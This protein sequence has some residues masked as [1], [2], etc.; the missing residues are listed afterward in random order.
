MLPNKPTAADL[1]APV[2]GLGLGSLPAA[3]PAPAPAS[4]DEERELWVRF[5]T[6]GD[7]AARRQLA[8]IYVSY[9]RALAA[10]SY[11]RRMHNEFEFDEYLH[12]GVIGMMEALDRFDPARG[13]LFKTFATPR[14]NGA[15]LNGLEGLSERQQQIGMRRRLAQERLQSMKEG[16]TGD[17]GGDQ[18]LNALSEIG[19]GLALGFLLEGTGMLVSEESHL[20][21]NAYSHLEMR[22]LRDRLWQM[23]EEATPREAQVIRRHY[24]QQQKFEDIAEAL[25]LTKG[26]ISQLHRQGIERLRRMIADAKVDVAW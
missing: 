13:A 10:R 25:Q 12:F 8:E 19:V 18:V 15:I 4:V 6:Q 9:T 3:T 2:Y 21:D 24:L 5:R 11:S 20:P 22:Q 7:P 23:V 1:V 17:D 16:G 14:I 26:R